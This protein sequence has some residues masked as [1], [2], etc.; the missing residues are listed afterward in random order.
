MK[1]TLLMISGEQLSAALQ[2][3]TH[4]KDCAR[5]LIEARFSATNVTRELERRI[6][7]CVVR[8]PQSNATDKAGAVSSLGTSFPKLRAIQQN[9]RRD[10]TLPGSYSPRLAIEGE[11]MSVKAL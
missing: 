4:A 10:G 9:F 11:S 1:A 2:V 3:A 6:L 7:A 8:A 5:H